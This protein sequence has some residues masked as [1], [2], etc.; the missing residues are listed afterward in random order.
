MSTVLTT[1]R[2]LIKEFQRKDAAFVLELVNTPAWLKY[3]G[4]RAVYNLSDA[5]NYVNDRL[6]AAYKT[7]GFGM[8]AVWHKEHNIA[9]G[10]CGLV[11]RDYLEYP[12]LGFAFLSAFTRKGYAFEASQAVLLFA[13]QQLKLEQLYA[14]TLPENLSS[15]KL[16]EKLDFQYQK[17]FQIPN[18]SD[19]LSL[20]WKGT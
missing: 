4:D 12:D 3:I 17:D 20:Y 15:I 10:M 16:L 19:H 5:E 13:Q 1:D 18:D 2:L 14:F 8:Y 9:I 6:M 7:H 11:Q